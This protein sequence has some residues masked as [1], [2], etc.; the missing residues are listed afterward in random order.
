MNQTKFLL[1]NTN[2]DKGGL[3][4]ELLR[5]ELSPR[6]IPINCLIISN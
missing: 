4:I 5:I 6:S 2:I 3:Y 1:Y